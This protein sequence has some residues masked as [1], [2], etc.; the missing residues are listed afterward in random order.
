VLDNL[1]YLKAWVT[2]TSH[3]HEDTSL[4]TR[5]I[6][7]KKTRYKIINDQVKINQSTHFINELIYLNFV[8]RA[9]PA[10]LFTTFFRARFLSLAFAFAFSCEFS[11]S[12]SDISSQLFCGTQC[13]GGPARRGISNEPL[14][15]SLPPLSLIISWIYQGILSIHRWIRHCLRSF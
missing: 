12:S 8:T 14:W 3:V 15:Y 6:K 1:Y 13:S 2:C 10:A 11:L 9:A 7:V 5:Q 4:K